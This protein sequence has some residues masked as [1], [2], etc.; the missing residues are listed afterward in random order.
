MIAKRLTVVAHLN[1]PHLKA[2]LAKADALLAEPPRI[3]L[4]E[5]IG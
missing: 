5:A 1:R 4:W 2:L 3:T